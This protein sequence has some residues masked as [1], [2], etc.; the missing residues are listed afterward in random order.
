MDDRLTLN[1][2]A[3]YMEWT[4]YL[5]GADFGDDGEWW[6]GGTVNAGGAETTGVEMQ[7]RLESNRATVR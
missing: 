2:S 5:Q 7:L 1:A 3:F 6:L 4:D